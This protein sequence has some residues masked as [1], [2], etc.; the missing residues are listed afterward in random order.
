MQQLVSVLGALVIG[1]IFIHVGSQVDE[2]HSQLFLVLGTVSI[3]IGIESP[4]LRWFLGLRSRPK[5]PASATNLKP[6]SS[7]V[8]AVLI[9]PSPITI[10]TLVAFSLLTL[11]VGASC[12]ALWS[13]VFFGDSFSEAVQFELLVAL[14]SSSVSMFYTGREFF[15]GV[16]DL[17]LLAANPDRAIQFSQ[18][19]IRFLSPLLENLKGKSCLQEIGGYLFVSKSQIQSIKF[20]G[21]V[22]SDRLR[23]N[24][25]R[26][27]ILL[28]GSSEPVVLR[29]ELIFEYEEDF[30]VGVKVFLGLDIVPN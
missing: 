2:Q 18:D 24:V 5:R 4:F 11:F 17:T 8:F 1:G 28:I 22:S 21:H 23:G 27:E 3:F 10:N 16:K 7:N 30:K 6:E 25:G 9:A 20:V 14:V 13:L 26:V 12:C 29:R 19:G 15:N